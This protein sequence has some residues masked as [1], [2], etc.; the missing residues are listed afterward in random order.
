[1]KTIPVRHIAPSQMEQG[2]TGHFSIRAIQQ[3]LDGKDLVHDLHKHDFFFI[4]ALHKTRGLHEI[5]F[6]QYEVHDNSIFIVRPGQVHR[7]ELKAGSTGFL[8]AFDMSFYQPKNSITDQRW[9]KASGKTYCEIEAGRFIKL[10]SILANIFDEFTSKKEGYA[11]AIKANLDL[12]FIEHIRQSANPKGNAK[13]ESGHT[14]EIFEKLTELLEVNIGS[15]KN[16]SQYADLLNLSSY[17]LNS[18]TKISVGKTVS[19]LINEQIILE[20]K[21]YLL[22][23]PNQVKDVADHLGYEDASYF[24]RFFKKHIGLS[25]EAFRKNFK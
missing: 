18:V 23:T 14:Q 24:I 8:M 21:R 2:D 1:M 6:V 22:A 11:E 16:V 19:D 15:M 7:L 4:L 25:P 9:K 5:D 3:M 10:H 17:Q 20:A 12:F 13:T